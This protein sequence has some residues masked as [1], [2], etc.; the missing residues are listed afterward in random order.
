MVNMRVGLINIIYIINNN[1]EPEN[2]NN[3]PRNSNQWENIIYCVNKGL[4]NR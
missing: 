2:P 4:N 3:W 1:A